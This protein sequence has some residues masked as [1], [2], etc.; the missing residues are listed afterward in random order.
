MQDRWGVNYKIKKKAE[1]KIEN[2]TNTWEGGKEK[3]ERR[4]EQKRFKVVFHHHSS[5]YTP[6]KP[7]KQNR[8]TSSP[9]TYIMNHL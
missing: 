8:P 4:K 7:S 6:L 3:G 2:R 5:S 1:D 9:T